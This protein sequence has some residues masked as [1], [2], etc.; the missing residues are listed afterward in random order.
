MFFV[1]KLSYSVV[2][3]DDVL[4]LGFGA[5]LT[6]WHV[7]MSLHGTKTQKKNII[8]LTAMKMSNHTFR[9]LIFYSPP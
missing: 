4:L 7:P 9:E 8:I 2:E 6:C 3:L 1:L 5:M